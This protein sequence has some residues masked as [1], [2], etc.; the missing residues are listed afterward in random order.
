MQNAKIKMQNDNE[1]LK[2]NILLTFYPFIVVRYLAFC[3]LIFAFCINIIT[4]KINLC[5]QI[6]FL[7]EKIY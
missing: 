2:I 3:S 5:V 7:K 1:K 6:L 4:I